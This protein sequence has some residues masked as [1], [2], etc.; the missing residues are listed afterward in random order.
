MRNVR[1]GR[2]VDVVLGDLDDVGAGV[3][4]EGVGIG[5]DGR[6]SGGG[7]GGGGRR[8]GGHLLLLR[9]V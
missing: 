6:G 5:V 8:R 7:G 2:A 9:H 4:V 3:E 1:G